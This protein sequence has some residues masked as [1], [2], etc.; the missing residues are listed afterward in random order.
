MK[1]RFYTWLHKLATHKI[2]QAVKDYKYMEKA[3]RISDHALLRYLER[4]E[5]IDLK[6]IIRKITKDTQD[7][8]SEIG[9]EGSFQVDGVHYQCTNWRIVTAYRP[10]GYKK[11]LVRDSEKG[12]RWEF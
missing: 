9:G 5:G 8:M 12:R 10:K 4:I 11:N 1:L 2:R 3:H 7:G 6:G